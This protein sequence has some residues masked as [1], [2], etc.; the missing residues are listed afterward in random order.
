MYKHYKEAEEVLNDTS[1]HVSKKVAAEDHMKYLIQ[2][3][4]NLTGR[5]SLEKIKRMVDFHM[6]HPL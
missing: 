5:E 1:Q 2:E 4:N 3:M 6:A